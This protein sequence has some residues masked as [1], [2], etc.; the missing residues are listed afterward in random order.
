MN[1]KR[2]A[3]Q[4]ISAL[5]IVAFAFICWLVLISFYEADFW[6]FTDPSTSGLSITGSIVLFVAF[7]ITPFFLCWKKLRLLKLHVVLLFLLKILPGLLLLISSLPQLNSS[8]WGRTGLLAFGVA[9]LPFMVSWILSRSNDDLPAASDA[10]KNHEPSANF[11]NVIEPESLEK[12]DSTPT[13]S[14]E[15]R[16]SFI[17]VIILAAIQINITIRYSTASINVFYEDWRYSCALFV[18][19][20]LLAALKSALLHVYKIPRKDQCLPKPNSPSPLTPKNNAMFDNRSNMTAQTNLSDN[21]SPSIKHE[22][23]TYTD[24]EN[25]LNKS[26][27]SSESPQKVLSWPSALIVGVSGGIHGVNIG[28]LVVLF[29]W[30]FSSPH[31]L[32]RW[33]GLDPYYNGV[34]V[35]LGLLFGLFATLLFR[36]ER[37]CFAPYESKRNLLS[38]KQI[39]M[40][41]PTE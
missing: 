25:T 34:F 26:E 7:C 11:K 21:G 16:D 9:L 24:S 4:L 28:S 13:I 5:D 3:F 6:H 14:S 2:A 29:V 31:I 20:F 22:A 30:L 32:C 40:V 19:G 8:P 35:V 33:S 1:A 38:E 37:L 23:T 12:N 10:A 15:S 18:F 41:S 27:C 17:D 39:S 36:P